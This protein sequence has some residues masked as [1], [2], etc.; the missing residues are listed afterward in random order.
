MLLVYNV[1]FQYANNFYLFVQLPVVIENSGLVE[2]ALKWNLGYLKKHSGSGDFF[3]YVSQDNRFKVIWF[4]KF[5]LIMRSK[6][7]ENIYIY[8]LLKKLYFSC[9]FNVFHYF[10]LITWSSS[11]SSMYKAMNSQ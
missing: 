5:I 3:V 7:I 8:T 1:F 6:E 9:F 2:P 4:V 11:Q 10:A